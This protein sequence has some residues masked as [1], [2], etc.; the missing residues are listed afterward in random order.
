M[1]LLA[2]A[3]RLL[4][5]Y[6]VQAAASSDFYGPQMQADVVKA[7]EAAGEQIWHRGLL[8]KVSITRVLSHF[9]CKDSTVHIVRMRL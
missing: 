7:G 1:P 2:E 5:T 8:K 6:G 4:G 9:R 3:H